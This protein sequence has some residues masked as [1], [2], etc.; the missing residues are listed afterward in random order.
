MPRVPTPA[1][2]KIKRRGRTEATG[3][4]HQ[5]ARLAQPYLGFAAKIRHHDLAAIAFDLIR[6]ESRVH[7][8]G[9]KK[10]LLKKDKKRRQ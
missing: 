6:A 4:D 8:S 10:P 9:K 3:A 7:I 1:A 2:A 5:H